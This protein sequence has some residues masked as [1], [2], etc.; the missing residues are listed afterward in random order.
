M[1]Q[2]TNGTPSIWR[3]EVYHAA[4]RCQAA[5]LSLTARRLHGLKPVRQMKR[6]KTGCCFASGRKAF[7]TWPGWE[8]GSAFGMQALCRLKGVRL[9]AL[10]LAPDGN[11]NSDPHVG[12]RTHRDC[13]ALAFRPFALII[14]SSPLLL[15]GRLPGELKQGIAQ[16][17]DASQPSVGPGIRPA[18]KEYWR[19]SCQS[20][21]AAG[22]GIA[23]TVI[24]DFRLPDEERDACLP[25][26]DS[27]T[28]RCRHDSKKAAGSPCRTGRCLRPG[29]AV[30]QPK[31]EPGATWYG[32]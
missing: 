13:V 27:E 10:L 3:E 26:A 21:Q 28:A 15:L 11:E 24:A 14:G 2:W 31:P 17:L 12:E 22:I 30:G 6:Q 18:L 9:I 5:S 23:L 7:L 8:L 19:G 4:S 25:A 16:R 20:L 29:A 1:K 32:W